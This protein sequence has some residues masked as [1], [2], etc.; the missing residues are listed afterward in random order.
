ML[1]GDSSGIRSLGIAEYFDVDK[2]KG[3]LLN[4]DNG[5]VNENDSCTLIMSLFNQSAPTAEANLYEII[6]N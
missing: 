6:L 3:F 4:V 1:N 5:L 2:R